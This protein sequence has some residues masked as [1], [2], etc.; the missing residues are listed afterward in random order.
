MEKVLNINSYQT[1][2][3]FKK[4]KSPNLATQPIPSDSFESS[5]SSNDK[6]GRNTL[7]AILCGAVVLF[8][9]YKSIKYLKNHPKIKSFSKN[10]DIPKHKP[11]KQKSTPQIEAP[12]KDSTTPIKD[13]KAEQDIKPTE[14][15]KQIAEEYKNLLEKEDYAAARQKKQELSKEGF[16]FFNNKL[17]HKT[18][19]EAFN[20]LE[21]IPTKEI[22]STYDLDNVICPSIIRTPDPQFSEVINPKKFGIENMNVTVYDYIG[23]GDN[24]YIRDE[25]RLLKRDTGM[26]AEYPSKKRSWLM[27][28]DYLEDI[29]TGKYHY[30]TT[31]AFGEGLNI[32]GRPP[33]FVLSLE[34][35]YSVETIEALKNRIIK[36]GLI[37]D[38]IQRNYSDGK[39]VM[40]KIV[41]EAI[42]FMN[43]I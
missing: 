40:D 32:H 12:K 41:D 43:K 39:K 16:L 34:G 42:A 10:K 13:I 24:V 26:S 35:D 4:V 22:T 38:L 2:I 28:H 25:S 36:T 11:S 27:G 7:L 31:L 9:G 29:N 18:S 37:E 21:T 5:N 19:K 20:P 8:A 3:N 1:N 15:I 23:M 33:G 14:R 17:V 6:K 30:V